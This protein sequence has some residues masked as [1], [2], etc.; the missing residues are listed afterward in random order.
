MQ[1]KA[2]AWKPVCAGVWHKRSVWAGWIASFC[3]LVTQ[4][5]VYTFFP[6]LAAERGFGP[7]AI[8]FVFLV[9]GLANTAARIPAGWLVDRTKNSFIYA[10][11]GVLIAS[12]VTALVPHV[13]DRVGLLTL[14]AIF[15]AVSGTAG[16]AMGATLSHATAPALRGS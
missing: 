11:A 14:A 16:V 7:G 4:G 9:L 2:Q 6:P 5:V 12:V 1:S 13:K 10:L 3:G 8:G 15:G